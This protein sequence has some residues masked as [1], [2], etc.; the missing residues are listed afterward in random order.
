MKMT[1]KKP[2]VISALTSVVA[3]ST[4]VGLSA[5]ASEGKGAMPYVQSGKS[6]PEGFASIDQLM[7]IQNYLD[8]IADSI[9]AKSEKVDAN[10]Y[11]S[12]GISPEEKALTLHWKGSVP[13]SINQVIKG[14]Q[15]KYS[16]RVESAD[17][18]KLELS[19]AMDRI[20]EKWQDNERARIASLSPLADGSGIRVAIV[21]DV[22]AARSLA[23]IRDSTV[24]VE[25]VVGKKSSFHNNRQLDTSPYFGGARYDTVL[26]TCST[27]F[28]VEDSSGNPYMLSAGHCVN[29]PNSGVYIP[30][31]IPSK[32]EE[33]NG[34]LTPSKE[35]A[36]LVGVKK[37]SVPALDSAMLA[38][39]STMARIYRGD[40]W[41][42]AT[43]TVNGMLGTYE[44]DYICTSGARTG[45]HCWGKVYITG[46]RERMDIA[47][48][49]SGYVYD[50]AWAKNIN[51]GQVMIA[52]GDSGGPVFQHNQNGYGVNA[53]G[54]I[55]MGSGG[56]G[57]SCTG[58]TQTE[59]DTRP[60]TGC[61]DY[62]GFLPVVDLLKSYGSKFHLSTLQGL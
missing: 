24:P 29:H 2:Y 38:M 21:G 20:Q 37:Y 12:I 25:L 33:V 61:S 53:K 44:G 32:W 1:S 6:A 45:E 48:D 16:A 13:A 54:I 14:M 52:H 5:E 49:P 11:A 55:S 36:K 23:P 3:F 8:R 22:E 19:A 51:P 42:R 34:V 9:V 28:A 46:V 60:D 7:E 40:T 57:I 17:Y 58:Y 10:G 18:S 47:P 43:S 39:G 15:E 35:T 30:N 31:T 27:G 26:G 41:S 59:P 56:G 4:L 50:V 62:V